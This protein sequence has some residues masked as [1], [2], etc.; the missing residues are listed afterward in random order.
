MATLRHWL[1]GDQRTI[2]LIGSLM[3]VGTLGTIVF[4]LARQW[5]MTDILVMMTAALAVIF[6][7]SRAI[8]VKAGWLG[9]AGVGLELIAAALYWLP[10][11]Y[12][13]V[14][15]VAWLPA[16]VVIYLLLRK[17]IPERDIS[18]D[19]LAFGAQ[20]PS[21][22]VSAIATEAAPARRPVVTDPDFKYLPPPK[23]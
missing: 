18:D 2:N 10:L 11:R 21:T 1:A 23:P 3:L 16:A 6:V 20:A 15:I 4:A 5:L 9:V 17:R 12:F 13:Y 7:V 19:Q 14:S 8:A 22:E